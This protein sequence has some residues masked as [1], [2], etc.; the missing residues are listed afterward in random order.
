MKKIRISGKERATLFLESAWYFRDHVYTRVCD[1]EDIH[2]V[3]AAELYCHK[4]CI[5]SYIKSYKDSKRRDNNK[6]TKKKWM[7]GK[8]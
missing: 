2:S 5:N 7:L 1:L 3:F 6:I 8:M 4:L